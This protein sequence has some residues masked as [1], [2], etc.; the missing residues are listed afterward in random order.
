MLRRAGVVALALLARPMVGRANDPEISPEIT[1]MLR[2]TARDALE[3]ATA[4]EREGHA[5]E[6]EGLYRR[7][8][9]TDPGLLAAH[10][11]YARML[12][13]RGRRE[14]ARAALVRAPRRAWAGDDAATLAYA[15]AL[16][17]L[18]ALDE[19]LAVLREPRGSVAATRALAE[20]A[21]Q[22]GRHPEA[23]AAARRLVELTADG[24]GAREARVLA[25]ALA[26]LVAEADAVRTPYTPTG[27]R[28]A[29]R[30]D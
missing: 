21:A 11:G 24:P 16:R 7:A 9:D 29:L 10:L 14:E 22:E 27:F 12:D 23:L 20:T 15:A 28:R 1:A 6:A 5:L 4:R 30:G 2:A 19:S 13:G 26:R 25:R 3:H 8:L 17:A 18:G